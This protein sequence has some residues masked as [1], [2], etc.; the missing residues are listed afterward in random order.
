M[1]PSKISVTPAA[2]KIV[3][4]E[5]IDAVIHVAGVISA[6]NAAGFEKGNVAGTLA[7]LAAVTTPTPAW[8]D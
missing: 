6:P 7:M 2:T 4:Q 3:K 5:G 8:C 1:M